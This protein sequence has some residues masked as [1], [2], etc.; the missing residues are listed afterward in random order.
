MSI[1]ISTQQLRFLG[2]LNLY[3]LCYLSWFVRF[4]VCVVR[5]RLPHCYY[6]S[7]ILIYLQ[8]F[9]KKMSTIYYVILL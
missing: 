8:G 7:F 1:I 2:G 9:V 5:K 3:L 6:G 4:E